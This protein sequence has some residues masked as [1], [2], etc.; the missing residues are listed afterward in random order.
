MRILAPMYIAMAAFY[1]PL[2]VIWHIHG[3]DVL[4]VAIIASASGAFGYMIYSKILP[5]VEKRL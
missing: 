5:W 1:P 4:E 3:K 2:L